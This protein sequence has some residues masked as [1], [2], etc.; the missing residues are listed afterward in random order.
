M[1]HESAVLREVEYCASHY[2]FFFIPRNTRASKSRDWSIWKEID[3]N[4]YSGV[5]WRS[6]TGAAFT[7]KRYIKFGVPGLP[8]FMGFLFQVAKFVVLEAKAEKGILSTDQAYFEVL[9]NKTGILYGLVRSYQDAEAIFD[10]LNDEFE[11]DDLYI[12]C[13]NDPNNTYSTQEK[14]R[15]KGSVHKNRFRFDLC[16]KIR[17]MDSDN[18]AGQNRR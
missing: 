11:N 5:L 8:D 7:G 10:I 17:T 6:N 4:R 15:E 12:Y 18:S 14:I 16:A 13:K 2:G 1:S 9:A 3:P